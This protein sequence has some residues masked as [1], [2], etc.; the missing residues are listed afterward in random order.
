[1]EQGAA[2]RGPVRRRLC[3]GQEEGPVPSQQAAHEAQ[4]GLLDLQL[5]LLLAPVDLIVVCEQE[6]QGGLLLART[7]N[8]DTGQEADVRTAET[9]GL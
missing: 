6:L 8:C 5:Q 4:E 3:D 1:M 7:A 9:N 2:V